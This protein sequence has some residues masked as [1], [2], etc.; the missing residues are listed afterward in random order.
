MQ[1]HSF[2]KILVFPI[3]MM[4]V[5]I[6]WASQTISKDLFVYIS[7]PVMLLVSLYVLHGPIDHWFHTRYPLKLD[8]KLRSWLVQ[9]FPYYASLSTE[10]IKKFES[11]LTLY[12]NARL[13]T[14]QGAQSH[15]VPEDIK[16]MIAAHAIRI[17][18][19]HEDYLIGDMDR[20][21]V[22]NHQFPTPDY[23]FLHSMEINIEDGVVILNLPQ[24]IDSIFYPH[25]YYN[26]AFHAYAEAFV[27]VNKD[28]IFPQCEDTWEGIQL[29]LNCTR[30]DLLNHT[31]WPDLPLLPIHITLYFTHHEKYCL[32]FPE[33]CIQLSHLFE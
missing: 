13:F 5:G 24:L 8:G 26:I 17:S 12:L 27:R 31:G 29:I 30:Q 33:I 18:L 15:E 1:I 4:A 23:Q 6:Y 16:C 9:H 2:S 22:Y 10:D 25:L 28:I 20:I 3:L 14:A 32:Q 21:F 19:R 7:I 11:R